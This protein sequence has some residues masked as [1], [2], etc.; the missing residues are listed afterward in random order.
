MSR[1]A[2]FIRVGHS[3]VGDG[4]ALFTIAEIG[5]NHG[6]SLKK[7]LDLVDA[8]AAAG[9]SAIKLQTLEADKLVAPGA[10]A[11]SHVAAQSMS[12]FFAGFELDEAAHRQIVAGARRQGLAVMATPFSE[13]AVDLLERV[14]VDAYKVASGDLT[15]DGLI[16]KVSVTGKPVVMSTGMAT[17]AEAAHALATARL[18]G[19]SSIALLHCVSAYPTPVG[20]ENLRAI[21]TLS[22]A[23]SI[24]VGLSDHSGDLFSLPLAIAAGASLYERH[25]VLA[26]NDGSIDA[27]VSSDP[28]E[29]AS[30]VST[31]ARV[32]AAMGS[33]E[34]TCLAVEAPNRSA[35]RR[36][37]YAVRPLPA[38]HIVTAADVVALRPEVGLRAGRLNELIGTRLTRDLDA[39][40]PFVASDVAYAEPVSY[41]A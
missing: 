13:T 29:F 5:L 25:I 16:R 17:L 11:P 19:A 24:P 15:W 41:V 32:S 12:E 21:S 31:A 27:D 10:P 7:A 6:G 36:A 40:M 8:A 39:G 26:K 3:V 20:S 4:H 28:K 18:A 22:Q 9:A 14:G 37:L 2:P 35:S 33:G 38:G 23:F 30:L 1:N 34:K